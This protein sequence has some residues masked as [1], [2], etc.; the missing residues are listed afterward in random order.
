MVGKHAL[1]A[2]GI[3]RCRDVIIRRGINHRGVV[4]GQQG[5]ERGIDLDVGSTAGG[6]AIDVVA[7]GVGGAGVPAELYGMAR[8]LRRG[9]IDARD[10]GSVDRDVLDAGSE[11]VTGQAGRDNIGSVGEARETVIAGAVSDG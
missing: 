8:F 11:G 6:T 7:D 3:D 4:V 10:A 1:D 2:G 5:D 9:E